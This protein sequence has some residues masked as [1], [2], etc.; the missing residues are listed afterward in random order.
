M[1]AS[2]KSTMRSSAGEVGVEPAVP[3]VSV[4]TLDPVSSNENRLV[5]VSQLS[6]STTRNPPMPIEATRPPPDRPRASSMLLRSPGAQRI[7]LSSV[8]AVY[9][10][11]T[12]SDAVSNPTWC[13]D[14]VSDT[15]QTRVR[16]LHL[17]TQCRICRDTHD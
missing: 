3:L 2:T 17:R 5:P 13:L 11:H 8:A 6:A 4:G 7:A 9:K 15:C 1:T 12:R 14:V 10:N 16:H